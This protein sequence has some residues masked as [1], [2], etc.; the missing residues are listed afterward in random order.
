MSIHFAPQWVKPIKPSGAGSTPTTEHPVEPPKSASAAQHPFPAL[1]SSGGGNHHQVHQS[2]TNPAMSYSRV[3]HTPTTPG[4]PSDS[5]YFPYTESNGTG[6]A[7]VPHPFR[8]SRE[9]ILALWDEDKV[10]ETPIELADM[11]PGGGVL[12]SQGVIRPNG[13]RELSDVEKKVSSLRR[14]G[15]A[16]HSADNSSCRLRCILRIRL[17]EPLRLVLPMSPALPMAR[18]R[19]G[20]WVRP[21]GV[22]RSLRLDEERRHS[23]ALAKA[24]SGLLEEVSSVPEQMGMLGCP[25]L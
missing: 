9:Q 11:M 17:G 19:E 12:L 4:F 5:S 18:L 21:W 3:T 13:L 20:L 15:L 25:E 1:S 6:H 8:Y 14:I 16:G 23:E 22:K 7:E 10:R 24:R 2:N